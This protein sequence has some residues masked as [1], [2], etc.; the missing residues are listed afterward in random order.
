M[1]LTSLVA[2][3]ISSL[4]MGAVLLLPTSAQAET[5]AGQ[6]ILQQDGDAMYVTSQMSESELES[7][8]TTTGVRY[9]R[10]ADGTMSPII[11]P[12][13]FAKDIG[14]LINRVLTFIFIISALLV[15]VYLVWGSLD[16]I[17]SGGDKGKTEKARNKMVSAVVGLIIIL[18]SYA[19]INLVVQYFTSSS[20]NEILQNFSANQPL[21]SVSPA[22]TAS[23]SPSPSAN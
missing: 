1:K 2:I 7:A 14:E 11:P 15:F 22:P 18:A 5:A 16:W 20:L 13:A 17:T 8:T 21:V 6:L 9:L 23:P 19:A 3:F 4:V 10:R 12:T